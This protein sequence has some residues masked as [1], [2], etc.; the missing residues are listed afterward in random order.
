MSGKNHPRVYKR[1]QCTEATT[2]ET[3]GGKNTHKSI[4][5]LHFSREGDCPFCFGLLCFKD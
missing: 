5:C 3:V 1:L 4:I 2:F